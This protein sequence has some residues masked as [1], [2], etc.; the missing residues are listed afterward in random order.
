MKSI[1]TIHNLQFQGRWDIKTIKEYSGLPDYVFTSDKLEMYKDACMLKGGLVYADKITTVSNTYA[2]EIQSPQYG[3]GLN[4]LLSARRESLWGIVNGIDYNDYDPA[5]DPKIYKKYT[6][7]NYRKN[8]VENKIQLQ[9]QLGLPEDKGA[10]MIGI[11]SR[12]TDQK[13]LDLVDRIMNDICTDGTQFVV[14]GTGD[15]RYEDMFKYYQGIHPAKVSANIYYSDD[16]SHKMYAACDAM[17]VPSRFEP[18]GLTQLMALRYGTLP[19]VRETGGLKDTVQPYNEFEG[20]G[21]GFSFAN[22][23]ARE[24]LNTINYSK[25]IFF[26]YKEAWYE[27]QARAMQQNYSWSNS[28]EI[29]QRLYD[30]V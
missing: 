10:Y 19:I 29:Y 23:D 8:K 11:I 25:R 28:A 1:M 26:D 5:T 4:G 12:L 15:R 13:G 21:T 2:M 14:L 18:C 22:Y 16:L 7:K 6:I 9:K 17:L 27:M 30:Q 20:S 24:L 3:E